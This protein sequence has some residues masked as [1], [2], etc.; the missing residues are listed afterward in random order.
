MAS[1][2]VTH[3]N[4]MLPACRDIDPQAGKIKV[5]KKMQG[6]GRAGS[7]LSL[8]AQKWM[9]RDGQQVRSRDES[10]GSLRACGFSPFHCNCNLLL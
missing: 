6:V 10:V 9:I 2:T 3:M 7:S 5:Q 8:P 4:E 1:V